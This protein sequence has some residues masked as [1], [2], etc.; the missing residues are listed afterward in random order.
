MKPIKKSEKG[1]ILILLVLA[2]IGLLGITALAL[3]GSM[4][5]ADRR[6][7]QSVADSASLSGGNKIKDKFAAGNITDIDFSCDVVKDEAVDGLEDAINRAKEYYAEIVL[8]DPI[9]D[10]YSVI[11]LSGHKFSVTCDIGKKSLIVNVELTS[12]TNTAFAHLIYTGLA[13]NTVHAETEVVANQS[14][15]GGYAI[16]SLSQ[17][18]RNNDG[19]T[20]LSG[21][22]RIT[23]TNG[24]A[25][26][27]SCMYTGGTSLYIDSPDGPINYDPADGW[28]SPGNPI[29]NPTPSPIEDDCIET[30]PFQ[31]IFD[32]LEA[33]CAAMDPVDTVH[34]VEADG[35]QTF[36]QG[37]YTNIE[38]TSDKEMTFN[39]GLYCLT[40]T[41]NKPALKING[42]VVTAND[43]TFVIL[44]GDVN[45]AGNAGDTDPIVLQAPVDLN[46]DGV[47]DGP[48]SMVDTGWCVPTGGGARVKL[49]TS[50]TC[51]PG[52]VAEP[53]VSNKAEPPF[54]FYVTDWGRDPIFSL[55]GTS[56]SQYDG[57]IY[58]PTSL[59]TIGGTSSASTATYGTTIIGYDV[60]I[61]GG[62]EVDV[63]ALDEGVP[64]VS[65]WL[66]F[67]K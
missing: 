28:S 35:S 53:K 7:T 41:G 44:S 15:T 55:L 43:V 62:A 14:L 1:Q 4:I 9:S 23:L 51:E 58:A 54:L 32:N 57:I 31:E 39:P 21:T 42:G 25:C 33:A 30:D 47:I 38:Q 6:F 16:I 60:T 22:P 45:V 19:G 24:G 64:S 27:N 61:N 2:I 50:A 3:D 29:V 65:G 5:Y 8:P 40:H 10:P 17:A 49:S 67:L 13:R 46:N 56:V 18:C 12:Q 52:Y 26:S 48:N 20:W 34:V 11:E 59:V 66:D 37:I 36:Y 63:I